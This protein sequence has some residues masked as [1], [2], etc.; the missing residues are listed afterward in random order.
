MTAATQVPLTRGYVALVDPADFERVT[1][2]SPW[3]AYRRRVSDVVYAVGTV[4]QPD[5][6]RRRI[7]L[8]TFLTGWPLVDHINGDGLDN[9]RRNLRPATTAQNIANQRL[10]VNNTSG[11]KGVT[12][13]GTLWRAYIC[14]NRRTIW[15]GTFTTPE[16]AAR[17]YDE[18]ALEFFGEF[19]RT[20]FPREEYSR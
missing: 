14:P 8:H 16:D 5:G 7:R 4:K 15:L 13:R 9:R 3:S 10:H 19:A 12:R 18:A 20:N 6:R 2:Q 11:F 1:A 17:A